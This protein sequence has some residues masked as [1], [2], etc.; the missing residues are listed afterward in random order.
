[1]HHLFPDLPSNRLAQVSIRVRE[2]CEKYDLPYNT[3]SFPAQYFRTQR[4]IHKLALPDG[5]MAA[6]D[7]ANSN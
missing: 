5:L 7:A 3:G 1:E 4:T 2:L 6:A